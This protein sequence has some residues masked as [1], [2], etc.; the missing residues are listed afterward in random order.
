MRG[1]TLRQA[2]G[3]FVEPSCDLGEARQQ[4][5]RHQF[6]GPGGAVE[7][8]EA[9]VERARLLFIAGGDDV[10]RID[11]KIA[12]ALADVDVAEPLVAEGAERLVLVAKLLIAAA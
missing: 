5:R 8:R 12:D 4:A 6:P 10:A 2:A 3:G 7:H 1:M 9:P 11:M